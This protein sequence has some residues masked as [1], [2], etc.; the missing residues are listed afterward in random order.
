M[1]YVERELKWWAETAPT[2]TWKWS[3]TM[4]HNYPHMYLVKDKNCDAAIYDRL[5]HLILA[6][7]EPA[8]FF[9]RV[10]IELV[11]PDLELWFGTKHA[12]YKRRGFKF[13]AM[14]DRLYES[15]VINMAPMEFSYGIQDAPSTKSAFPLIY[16]E[17]AA[18]YDERYENAYAAHENVEVWKEV[19]GSRHIESLLDIG[20]GTGLALDLSFLGAKPQP[21]RYRAVEPSQ[22]MLNRLVYKHPWVRDICPATAENYF[23]DERWDAGRTFDTVISLFGSPSYIHPETIEKMHAVAEKVLVVMHCIEGYVPDYHRDGSWPEWSDAS[24]EAAAA[25]P[26]AEVRTMNKFQIVTVRK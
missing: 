25:L 24:R 1:D 23:S 5:F 18:G 4:A 2:L 17:V 14:T 3:T 26:R 20:A 22:G 11:M 8:K 12:G 16:D 13:W 10:N 15:R 6:A 7:G 21:E 9:S 19:V